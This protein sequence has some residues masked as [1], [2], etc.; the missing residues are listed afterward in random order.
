[1]PCPSS[2]RSCSSP[3]WALLGE[4][5]ERS[6][7]A[8]STTSSAT[9]SAVAHAAGRRSPARRARSRSRGRAR[10]TTR[11]SGR[12]RRARSP[13]AR[14]PRRPA[15]SGTNGHEP[16]H[17]LR[18]QDTAEG[19]LGRDDR[20]AVPDDARRRPRRSATRRP[21]WRR[22]PRPRAR[23]PSEPTTDPSVARH[24]G[25][26]H[27]ARP[28]LG[29]AGAERPETELVGGAS[30]REH[31][32]AREALDL[33]PARELR[34]DGEPRLGR[35]RARRTGGRRPRPSPRRARREPRLARPPA[36]PDVTSANER[37]EEERIELR[38]RSR[39]RARSRRGGGRPCEERRDARRGQGDGERVE[40]GQHELAEEERRG[41]DEPEREPRHGRPS[42]GAPSRATAVSTTVAASSSVISAANP[43]A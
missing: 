32:V 1:M 3:P 8:A 6:D 31:D 35:A 23:P 17:E 2:P 26:P 14:R 37:H 42:R 7:G 5:R 30:E 24:V 9:S 15:T 11:G 38:R 16:E 34:A 12:G 20:R 4:T 36:P 13:L 27:V 40:A 25:A 33:E 18:R 19:D 41:G 43:R 39:G 29:D 21:T 10:G 28:A 22:P